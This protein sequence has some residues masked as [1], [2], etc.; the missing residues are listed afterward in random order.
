MADVAQDFY[1]KFTAYLIKDR[2]CPNPRQNAIKKL[3]KEYIKP[4][5]MVLEIGCG[6][7]IISE[8]ISKLIGRKGILV[9]TDLSNNNIEYAKKTVK[10]NNIRFKVA[11]VLVEN[12]PAEKFNYILLLD[13]IEH[14][15]KK[16]H[17]K[18]IEKLVNCL[19]KGGLMIFTLP[20]P[21]YQE[22]LKEKQHETLQVVDETITIHEL[23]KLTSAFGLKPLF[24]SYKHIFQ[25][26]QYIHYICRKDLTFSEKPIERSLTAQI[27]KNLAIPYKKIFYLYRYLRYVKNVKKE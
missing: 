24:F 26:W 14:I 12:L 15:P 1:E 3:L 25:E 13:L 8:Y 4:G 21:E 27:G 16:E 6:I 18:L 11:D 9:A 22:Y 10:R 17:S 20:S 23:I 5:S 7:G 19:R 2:L